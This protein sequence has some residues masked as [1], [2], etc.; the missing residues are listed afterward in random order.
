M[1]KKKKLSMKTAKKRTAKRNIKTFNYAKYKK[2][3]FA[4]I[5]GI[6]G[7][8]TLLIVNAGSTTITGKISSKNISN[9]HGIKIGGDGELVVALS[10][11]PHNGRDN[12]R[13]R[14]ELKKLPNTTIAKYDSATPGASISFTTDVVAGDYAFVVSSLDQLTNRGS[15]YKIDIV[16]PDAVQENISDTTKPSVVIQSPVAGATVVNS[17][18][19]SGTATDAGE[20]VQVNYRFIEGSWLTALGTTSW[21]GQLDT[22]T[23]DNGARTIEVSVRDAAGNIGISTITINVQNSVTSTTGEGLWITASEIKSLPNSGSGWDNMKKTATSDLGTVALDNNDSRHDTAVLALA[24]YSIRNGDSNGISR[25]AQEISTVPSSPR[26]RAL[27]FC[28]NITSYIVAADVVNLQSINPTV[29]SNFRGFIRHWVFN[30]TTLQGHSGKGIS[31][32]AA[33]APNNWGGMCRA[34]YVSTAIYLGDA[35]ALENV[36]KWHKGFL[37]DNVTYN[38]MVY[39]DTNWHA[40]SNNKKG[41][42]AKGAT[43]NGYSVDGVIPEDQRRTGEFEWPAPQGEYPW[44]A[45]Q[46]ALVTDVMLQR[47]GK[48]T[49]TYQDSAMLRAYNWLYSVNNN[50]AGDDDRWQMWVVN[51]VYGKNYPTTTGSGVTPGKLMGW[52][53]WTHQ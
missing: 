35:T 4:G 49:T 26:Y 2:W 21:S 17:I 53:D 11:I 24:Y 16:Y 44:E 43:I 39:K 51:K 32:T 36:T 8:L 22:R 25:V 1:P 40:D 41:I 7:L 14:I 6:V 3:I 50:P 20:I 13:Y 27:E 33:K 52:T 23:V 48:I 45:M 38:G 28:R 31:G 46:G 34:A 42:N 10:N 19:V 37:G 15:E 12:V 30:D 18:T 47:A 29:D 9:T 5:F